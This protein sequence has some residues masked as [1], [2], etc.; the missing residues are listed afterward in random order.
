[1]KWTPQKAIARHSLVR[2]GQLGEL[3][4]VAAQV[5]QGDHLVLLVV[6]AED[7]QP[8]AHR[9]LDRV[10]ARGERGVVQRLVAVQ[11]VG[12]EQWRQAGR[13]STSN[14]LRLG[15]IRRSLSN[16]M[17]TDRPKKGACLGGAAHAFSR[18][19]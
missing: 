8:L 17:E 18:A 9:G 7:Q 11:V 10:N 14:V 13:Q 19:D 4:A 5:G 1:M 16:Y 15:K 2:G 3:V 6:M 12:W